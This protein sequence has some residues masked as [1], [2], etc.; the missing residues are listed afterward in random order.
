MNPNYVELVCKEGYGLS[1]QEIP[2]RFHMKVPLMLNS[3]HMAPYPE[4][5]EHVP[6]LPSYQIPHFFRFHAW[7]EMTHWR[8]YFQQEC[9]EVEAL[10]CK[11]LS[12][13]LMDPYLVFLLRL[14]IHTF[15]IKS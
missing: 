9:G 11:Q 1:H 3:E 13:S 15:H 8:V 2:F 10:C 14:G 5:M 4:W 12:Y 7:P 6:Y